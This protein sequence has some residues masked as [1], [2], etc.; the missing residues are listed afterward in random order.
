MRDEDVSIQKAEG[1]RA[2]R[3]SSVSTPSPATCLP[4]DALSLRAT[5]DGVVMPVRVIPRASRT[6]LAGV[7]DG[8]L[9]VRLNAPP[10]DGAA[11]EGLIR[12]LAKQLGVARR[13]VRI[14]GHAPH[15]V[16]KLHVGPPVN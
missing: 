14:V 1:G 2:S 16:A 4:A 15:L 10:I 3:A 7:R 8:R 11:N 12:L 6:V 13:R 5:D 9:L